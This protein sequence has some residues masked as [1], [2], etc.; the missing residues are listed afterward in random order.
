MG[1]LFPDDYH[2]LVLS[3]VVRVYLILPQHY[4]FVKSV[5]QVNFTV[6]IVNL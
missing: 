1:A 3:L 6:T 2:A 4:S 5:P